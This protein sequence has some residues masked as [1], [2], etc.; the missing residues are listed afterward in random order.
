M[1]PLFLLCRSLHPGYCRLIQRLIPTCACDPHCLLFFVGDPC[2]ISCKPPSL[3]GLLVERLLRLTF[4]HPVLNS[5]E[6]VE[7]CTSS[8]TCFRYSTLSHS[9]RLISPFLTVFACHSCSSSF[10][11]PDTSRARPPPPCDRR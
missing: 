6:D 4:P 2:R 8:F 9:T 5:E 1:G 3:L 11:V 7:C 10:L